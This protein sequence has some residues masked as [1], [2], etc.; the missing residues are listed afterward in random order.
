MRNETLAELVDASGLSRRALAERVKGIA[1][2]HGDVIQTNHAAVTYWINGGLPQPDT[3]RYLLEA[4]S[5]RLGRSL[6]LRDI[7][8]PSM[9]DG[10]D[11]IASMS[12]DPVEVL[13][14][15][16]RAEME[17]RRF[18][19]T[20]AYSTA[21]AAT[22]VTLASDAWGRACSAHAGGRVGAS[23]VTAVQEMTA[24][25]THIDEKYGGQHARRAVTAYLE[26]AL[27]MCRGNFASERVHRDM[28]S[29]TASLACLAAWKAYDAG[30]H[31]HAQFRYIQAQRLTMEAANPVHEA[32]VLRGRVHHAINIKTTDHALALAEQMMSRGEQRVD[33]GTRALFVICQAR[34]L[35]EEKQTDRAL[36]ES[37]RARELASAAGETGGVPGWSALWASPMSTVN[38][39]TAKILSATGRYREAERSYKGAVAGRPGEVYR[40]IN[41]L[42]LAD[43]GRMQVA[44]GHLEQAVN[45]F[46]R[47]LRTMTGVQSTR[48]L[49]S[50]QG[51]RESLAPYRRRGAGVV[52]DFDQS[53]RSW[54]Q[55]QRAG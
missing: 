43:A 45:T 28:L 51:M 21:A 31:G 27:Q 16:G 32:F 55:E 36:K 1:A 7:G 30:E 5:R 29:A 39:H 42:T 48:T 23:D 34:A 2:Q 33:G 49:T 6:T 9:D 24:V 11:G 52:R 46:D 53:L 10:L 8:M 12:E 13:I 40:R 26:D 15:L 14:E 22:P 35:A 19:K 41:G 47:A 17:R 54:L 44:Q 3:Q 25:Y 37:Y 4:L 50:A 20:A 18:L 38:S